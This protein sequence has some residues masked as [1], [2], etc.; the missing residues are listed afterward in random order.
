MPGSWAS[1]SSMV[2]FFLS[3]S[4]GIIIFLIES[5][6]PCWETRWVEQTRIDFRKFIRCPTFSQAAH[7]AASPGRL[8]PTPLTLGAA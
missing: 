4:A 5:V 8:R 6:A 1:A 7:Q 3:Q 2:I